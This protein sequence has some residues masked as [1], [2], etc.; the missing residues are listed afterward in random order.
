MASNLLAMASNPLGGVHNIDLMSEAPSTP[1]FYLLKQEQLQ[2]AEASFRDQIDI[3]DSRPG[4]HHF[5]RS[6]ALLSFFPGYVAPSLEVTNVLNV[7]LSG[8]PDRGNFTVFSSWQ[9]VVRQL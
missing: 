2:L 3:K 8:S 7:S 5:T 4:P 9:T 1:S 6:F